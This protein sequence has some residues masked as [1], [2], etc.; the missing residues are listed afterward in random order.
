MK[1]E[2]LHTA[3]VIMGT[4]LALTIAFSQYLAPERT[5][6]STEKAKTEQ[7]ENTGDEKGSL[8]SLPTFSIPVPVSV[9]VNLDAYCLFEIFF[10][11]DVDENYV[12]EDVSYSDRFFQLL[13]GVII[14]PNAP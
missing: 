1:K 4:I 11:E 14:S 12:E 6:S 9:Q 7:A 13:F 2:K 10:E 5:T 8:I 3:S